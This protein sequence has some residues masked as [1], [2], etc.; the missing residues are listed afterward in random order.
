MVGDDKRQ[1]QVTFKSCHAQMT[2]GPQMCAWSDARAF[3]WANSLLI[4]PVKFRLPRRQQ[5]RLLTLCGM[6][7]L[8]LRSISAKETYA[9]SDSHTHLSF[10][11]ISSVPGSP[12]RHLQ[13]PVMSD[14]LCSADV[15][16]G[17]TVTAQAAAA[18]LL[19]LS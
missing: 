17:A 15:G 10:L 2:T 12:A 8:G 6:K 7:L 5:N 9:G 18:A 4:V 11:K 13:R 3:A 1:W 16:P 14:R 19:P